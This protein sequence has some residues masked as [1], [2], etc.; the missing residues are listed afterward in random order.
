MSILDQYNTIVDDSITEYLEN[1]HGDSP[2]PARA[3]ETE[4]EDREFPIVGPL[5]GR[6]LELM[7]GLIEPDCIVELGS[8]F[9]YSAYWFGRGYDE[10][11]IHLTDRDEE[12]LKKAERYLAEA[13]LSERC[14]FHRGD[15]L[16]SVRSLDVTPDLVFVDIDKEGY[17]EA[18]QWAQDSLDPGGWVVADNVLREGKVV[19]SDSDE[20]SVRAIK[21]FNDELFTD[22]W[23]ASILPLR[24]G[25]AIARLVGE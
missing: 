2:G 25:V 22:R 9:G 13:S 21:A 12:N 19:D 7:A 4:A 15:A 1:L 18:L 24:D 6:F 14:E 5:V 16:E 11:T 10:A 3:M 20:A 8:G 17:P 23:D